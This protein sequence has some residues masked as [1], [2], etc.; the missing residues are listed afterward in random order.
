MALDFL[1]MPGFT[2]TVKPVGTERGQNVFLRVLSVRVL[3]VVCQYGCDAN[4]SCYQ[5][6]KEH[7]IS[8]N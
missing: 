8:Y 1:N 4:K 5:S 7:V 2:L 6:A 3:S